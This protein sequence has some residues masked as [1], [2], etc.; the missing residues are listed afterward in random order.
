MRRAARQA[1]A[2]PPPLV[3]RSLVLSERRVQPHSVVPAFHLPEFQR[4]PPSE[5]KRSPLPG[6]FLWGTVSVWAGFV[7]ILAVS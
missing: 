4:P 6:L 3:G 7:H 1:G 2:G 5:A